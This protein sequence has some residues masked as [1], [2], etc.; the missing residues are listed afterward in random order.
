MN[1]LFSPGQHFIFPGAIVKR[2]CS[3]VFNGCSEAL[4]E[5]LNTSSLYD[6]KV[7]ESL[8]FPLIKHN[9]PSLA[10]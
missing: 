9:Q 8:T 7:V 3:T 6:Y 1:F 4:S 2:V 10:A 5:L